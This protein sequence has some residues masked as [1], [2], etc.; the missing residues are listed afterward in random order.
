[1]G[2]FFLFLSYCPFSSVLY[3]SWSLYSYIFFPA[4]LLSFLKILHP[5]HCYFFFFFLAELASLPPLFHPLCIAP[6]S[7]SFFFLSACLLTQS[8][9][10]LEP[11]DP[12]CYVNGLNTDTHVLMYCMYTLKPTHTNHHTHRRTCIHAHVHSV[13]YGQTWLCSFWQAFNSLLSLTSWCSVYK[14]CQS[15]PN[16]KLFPLSWEQLGAEEVCCSGYVN[17]DLTIPISWAEC[18]HLC[19]CCC[20]PSTLP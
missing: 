6:S 1:M 10:L 14:S 2:V 13:L 11:R 20:S 15:Q 18:C 7:T 17:T 3:P 16:Q 12:V 5:P 9:N 4:F 19:K 8:L